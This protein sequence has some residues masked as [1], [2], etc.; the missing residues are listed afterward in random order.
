[1]M[2]IDLSEIALIVS[3]SQPPTQ[4]LN[5]PDEEKEEKEKSPAATSITVVEP[6]ESGF[7]QDTVSF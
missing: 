7:D 1:M 5:P 4:P 2:E 6:K 3:D